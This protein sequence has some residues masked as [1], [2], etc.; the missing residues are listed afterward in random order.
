MADYKEFITGTL[1]SLVGKA[2]EIAG[3]ET[4]TGIVEK[5]KT[6]AEGSQVY[7]V[8]EQGSS[9]AKQYARIAKLSLELNGQNEELGRIYTEIGKLYCEQ[10]QD[11]PGGFFEPLFQQAKA[12]TENIRAKQAEI[13]RIKAA[14]ETAKTERDIDVE[15]VEDLDADIAEFEQIVDESTEQGPNE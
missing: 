8:Y 1:N 2:K 13:D 15:I 7:G 10:M 3:S 4:V 9:R 5:V 6:A 11:N 14:L 12:V